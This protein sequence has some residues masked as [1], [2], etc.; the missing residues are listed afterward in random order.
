MQIDIYF[1]IA[2]S[3]YKLYRITTLLKEDPGPFEVSVLK[4]L[5]SKAELLNNRRV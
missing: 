5:S 1:I 4:S 2:S 3:I